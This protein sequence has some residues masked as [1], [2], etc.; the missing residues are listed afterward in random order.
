M[1]GK[2]PLR[3]LQTGTYDVCFEFL[4]VITIFFHRSWDKVYCVIRGTQIAFYKDTKSYKSTPEQYYK[5]E[6]PMDL[7]GATV[8]VAEDYTKKKHVFRIRYAAGKIINFVKIWI[9]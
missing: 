5:G 8:K 3:K 6:S 1:N 2:L 9:I 4:T 7:T